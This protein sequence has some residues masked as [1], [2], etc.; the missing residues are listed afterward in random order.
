[1][2]KTLKEHLRDHEKYIVKKTLEAHGGDK[3]SVARVLGVSVRA[4]NKILE[5]HGLVRSR[6][7]RPLP[8]PVGRADDDREA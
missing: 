3:E 5:R 8:I 2:A 1:M 6:F 7:A 4:L